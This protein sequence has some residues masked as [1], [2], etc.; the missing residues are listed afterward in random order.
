MIRLLLGKGA[1][2]NA[3]DTAKN[4]TAMHMAAYMGHREVCV[5]FRE[6]IRDEQEWR[7]FWRHVQDK[8]GSTMYD[9]AISG[10]NSGA[11]DATKEYLKAEG[12]LQGHD[13][14]MIYG[15]FIMSFLS[16]SY[17]FWQLFFP[18]QNPAYW[19]GKTE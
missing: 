1:D 17:Y 6:E 15:C 3:R 13:M 19:K 18:R 10:A 2:M 9:Y 7:K 12:V 16:L 4:S 5:L 14:L 11:G 8:D